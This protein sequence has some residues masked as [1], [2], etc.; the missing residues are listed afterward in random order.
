MKI[1]ALAQ[2]GRTG[3]GQYADIDNGQKLTMC[4][5]QIPPCRDFRPL[6]EPV[7]D[8]LVTRAWA[9]FLAG[10]VLLSLALASA[11]WL[12]AQLA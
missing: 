8:R 7:D 10:V 2:G 9:S 11:I 12:A 1:L 4:C 3:P 5:C 6:S